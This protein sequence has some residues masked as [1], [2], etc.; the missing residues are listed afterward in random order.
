VKKTTL[1]ELSTEEGRREYYTYDPRNPETLCHHQEPY[2]DP[3]FNEELL[4]AAGTD[5]HGDPR[6]RIVWAGSL[7]QTNFKVMDDGSVLEYEGMKYPYMRVRMVRGYI[8]HDRNGNRVSTTSMIGI[9]DKTPFVEDIVWYDLGHMKFVLEMKY[10]YEELVKL[11]R[12]PVPG[13]KE[14]KEW[15]ENKRYKGKRM[16]LDP[17]PNG[18][19]L[20]AHYIETPDGRYMDMNDDMMDKIRSVIFNATSQTEEAYIEQKLEL[21]KKAAIAAQEAESLR[22]SDAISNARIAAEK[23]LARGKVVYG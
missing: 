19:Y 7:R 13:S 17:N 23:R 5:I 21:R 9:P 4:E 18:E 3:R 16:R 6:M 14:D 1:K 11:G 15:H 10:T 22:L 20:F 8:Y 2:L 12:Y